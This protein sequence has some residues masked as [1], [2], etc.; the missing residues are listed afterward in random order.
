MMKREKRRSPSTLKQPRIERN[1][2]LILILEFW[3]FIFLTK[4]CQSPSLDFFF[5]IRL[6]LP[7]AWISAF[8]CWILDGLLNKIDRLFFSNKHLRPPPPHTHTNPHVVLHGRCEV[9]CQRNRRGLMTEFSPLASEDDINDKCFLIVVNNFA[10]CLP[11]IIKSANI[12]SHRV[13][14]CYSVFTT[15]KHYLQQSLYS[16]VQ[17]YQL[18]KKKYK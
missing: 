5:R 2:L 1:I 16:G 12:L 4:N 13:L 18:V 17:W 11:L 7:P 14:N 15:E 3:H 9:F 6:P 10:I 8:C